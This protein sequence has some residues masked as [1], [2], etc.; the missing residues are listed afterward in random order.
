MYILLYID[1]VAP[2]CELDV[3]KCVNG[4][5][6]CKVG[7]L[8]QDCCDCA[9][10]YY[11]D[12]EDGKCKCKQTNKGGTYTLLLSNCML[13]LYRHD[14]QREFLSCHNILCVYA[15]TAVPKCQYNLKAHC[16]DGKCTCKDGY[17]P[18]DCCE[19]AYGYYKDKED[20]KCKCKI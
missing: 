15:H 1:L 12:K 11:K 4:E 3:D 14:F 13:T 9:Y 5:C 19:C 16:V 8:P 10:G 2:R 18:Q 20:G 6:R 17:L 7:Y